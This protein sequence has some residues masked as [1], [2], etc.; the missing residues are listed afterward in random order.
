MP[1]LYD[2]FESRGSAVAERNATHEK[3]MDDLVKAPVAS[4]KETSV[5]DQVWWH[6]DHGAVRNF[7]HDVGE[8]AVNELTDHP[9]RVAGAAALGLGTG[10]AA[11]LAPELAIVIPAVSL[12]VGPIFYAGFTDGHL[13]EPILSAAA[14]TIRTAAARGKWSE[15]SRLTRL[16]VCSG[17]GVVPVLDTPDCLHQYAKD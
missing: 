2:D 10:I 4:K 15:A 7:F 6:D 14:K 13:G 9:W 17:G 16:L 5:S 11:T 3:W 12:L 1:G 8:G